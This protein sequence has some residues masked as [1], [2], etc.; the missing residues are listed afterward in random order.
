[1]TVGSVI[2][3]AHDEERVIRRCLDALLSDVAPGALE[4]VVVCNGCTDRT[5]QIAEGYAPAVRVLRLTEASKLAALRAGDAAATVFPRLY[6]D[7]DVELRGADAVRVLEELDAGP[8]LAARPPLHYDTGGCSL[9]VRRYY[10]ARVLVP[11]LMGRLWGAGVYGLSKAGHQRVAGWP[12][13]VAD[14][15]FVDS[16]FADHEIAIASSGPVVVHPPR[17]ASSLVAVLARG[18]QLKPG[19]AAGG[20]GMPGVPPRPRHGLRD[21]LK[22][23]LDLFRERPGEGIDV[24]VYAGIATL[25]RMTARN[26]GAAGWIRDE[27]S[28]AT[29]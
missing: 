3:P 28:R 25:S 7:A 10:R 22:G 24:A 5:A 1:V 16:S 21:T 6:L 15:L 23:L 26:R 9:L 12:D 11:G 29:S 14:D 19:S 4:V 13:G 18:I 8:A 20:A 17:T 27:S 2:V